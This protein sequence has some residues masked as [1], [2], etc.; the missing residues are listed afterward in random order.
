M[1]H[2]TPLNNGVSKLYP[3]SI[4]TENPRNRFELYTDKKR[5]FFGFLPNRFEDDIA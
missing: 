2:T 4:L 3:P 5:Q 1:S